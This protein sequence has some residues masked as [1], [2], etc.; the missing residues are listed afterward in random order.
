[1][2]TVSNRARWSGGVRSRVWAWLLVAAAAVSLAGCA[3]TLGL[4][5]RV[6]PGALHKKIFDGEWYF[7]RTVIDAPYHVG[8]TFVGETEETERVRF[9]IH[10]TKLV[11]YRAYDFVAGTDRAHAKD[12]PGVR[13]NG[14]PVAIWPITKHFDATR[15]YSPASGEQTNVL[16]ENADDRPW[17]ERDFIRVDWSTNLVKG[18]AFTVDGIATEPTDFAVTD[19]SDPDAFTLAWRDGDQ[20]TGW[21]ETRDPQAHRKARD[22]HYIDF[23]TRVVAKPEV[24]TW[25]DPWWGPESWPACWVYLNEDCKAAELKVRTALLR[26]DP[27]DDYEPLAYPDNAVLR[28]DKGKAIRVLEKVEIVEEDGVEVAKHAGVYRDPD[29]VLVRVPF[30]DRFGYFRTERYGVDEQYGEVESARRQYVSRW[31]LWQRSTRDDGPPL[32]YPERTPKPI[33]YY[34]SPGFPD[35]LLPA[36]KQVGAQWDAAFRETVAVLQGKSADAVPTLFELRPNTVSV[37]DQGVVTDRGQRVGDLRYSLLSYVAEPTRAGL[38]GYGPSSMDPTTGQVIAAAAHVYGGPLREFATSGRDLVRLARG[39]LDPEAFGLGQITSAQVKASLKA[40]APQERRNPGGAAGAKPKPTWQERTAKAKAWAGQHTWK[41]KRTQVHKMLKKAKGKGSAA[42]KRLA[43]LA[44]TPME[45]ALINRDV[46]LAFGSPADRAQLSKQPPGTPLPPLTDAQRA[47]MS[48]RAWASLAAKLRRVHR[49]RFLARHTMMHKAFA[50]DAVMGLVKQLE[51]KDPEQVWNEVFTA[52]FR[53]TAEHEVGHT[54][55]L[56]HNFEGSTDALNFHPEYWKL[57]GDKGAPLDQVSEA[58]KSAGMND[59]R[60]SSIMDYV[61]RFHSDLKGV[62]H[63]DK[64]AIAFGY[65]QLVQ[66]FGDKASAALAQSPIVRV[67]GEELRYLYQGDPTLSDPHLVLDTVNRG[68]AHYTKIPSMVG[69]VDNLQDRKWVPY[70]DLIDQWSG[71]G[72]T[73]DKPRKRTLHEVPFRFCSDEYV[74]GTTTCNIYDEGVSSDEIVRGALDQWR[75]H[76]VLNAFR[77]DRVDF[78]LDSYYFR[79][80]FRYFQ[81]VALQYQN[82]VFLQYDPDVATNPGVLWDWIVTYRGPDIGATETDWA[83]APQGGLPMSEAVRDGVRT[84]A[85]VVANPEPGSYCLDKE[86]GRYVQWTPDTSLKVCDKIETC[87]PAS[88]AEEGCADVVVPF[89]TGRYMWT[90]YDSETGY[91]FYDRLRHAGAFYDKL[92]AMEVLTDPSTYFIGVDSAQPINN[93]TL[94]MSIYFQ[95]ELTRMFGG[96]VAGRHD[97]VGWQVDDKRVLRGAD[98]FATTTTKPLDPL[99]GAPVEVPAMYLLQ[100]YAGFYGLAWLNANWDQTFHDSVK[101]WVDGH[102]E[103][104][105]LPAGVTVATLEHPLNHRVY[106]AVKHSD[107]KVFS[108]GYELVMHA[109][110]KA[111]AFEAAPTDDWARYELEE[112]TQAMELLRGLYDMFGYAWF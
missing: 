58:Q 32:P 102:G 42:S 104:V 89:G 53:S 25:W 75:D 16:V 15:T 8:Y 60:L 6:Q 17:Y 67:A 20:A 101:V 49:H 50:D 90:E 79:A 99:Q 85:S 110:S 33:V 65:G 59:Y 81:P 54:L 39:E 64:A 66:V 94:S 63:Y 23:V 52:V 4:I 86:L 3:E 7:Q 45:D 40:M 11:A 112:A 92:A 98:P 28:D 43:K 5:D 47:R 72:G 34:L 109:I 107:P 77:R 111:K 21:R 29:G 96:Y 1:M 62:G 76:Y 44:G 36:A 27:K 48:P 30:F 12:Q 69:G 73:A 108:G 26:V 87:T 35:A 55:G 105:T 56:R 70:Q 82:W 24:Y 61:G 106:K 103:S 57:R 14:T 68:L 37:D 46:A 2:G 19:P 91:Y 22:A 31:N 71:K 78:N 88:D 80:W 97:L 100:P 74:M 51:G 93:Y 13:V 95:K 84:L 18:F 83:K 41:S 9:E 10:E 38:L